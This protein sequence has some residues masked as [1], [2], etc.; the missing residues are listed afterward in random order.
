MVSP[1]TLY[2]A[3]FLQNSNLTIIYDKDE[4]ERKKYQK[5][6][7]SNNFNNKYFNET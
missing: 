2:M 4:K 7:V 1:L 6:D 3:P 5:P